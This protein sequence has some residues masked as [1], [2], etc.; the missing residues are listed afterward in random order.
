MTEDEVVLKLATAIKNGASLTVSYNKPSL[1]RMR[2]CSRTKSGNDVAKFT[3]Y[4]VTNSTVDLI[5]LNKTSLTINE[6]G[7]GNTGTFTV[8]LASQPAKDVAVGITIKGDDPPGRM[9]DNILDFTTSTWNTAQTVTVT[10]QYDADDW[11]DTATIHLTASQGRIKEERLSSATIA[12]TVTDTASRNGLEITPESHTINEGSSAKMSVRLTKVP[13]A[14]VSVSHQSQRD[15]GRAF[16]E[17]GAT[18]VHVRQ[19]QHACSPSRCMRKRM[20]TP[21]TSISS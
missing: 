20:R 21:T 1:V 18:G 13:A 2:R 5:V 3:D 7:S 9:D 8:K 11:N 15:R 10:G 19:L 16:I 14:D 12:L 6:S 4:T 17:P